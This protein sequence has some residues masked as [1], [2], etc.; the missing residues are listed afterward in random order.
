MSFPAIQ[1]ARHIAQ[2]HIQFYGRTTTT[3]IYFTAAAIPRFSPVDRSLVHSFYRVVPRLRLYPCVCVLFLLFLQN[4]SRFID[5]VVGQKRKTL[6]K[7][8]I[9]HKATKILRENNNGRYRFR[10][11]QIRFAHE[12]NTNNREECEL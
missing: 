9:S 7:K 6:Q 8:R 4:N 1:F 5:L 2:F 11:L 10:Y 3:P 12:Y